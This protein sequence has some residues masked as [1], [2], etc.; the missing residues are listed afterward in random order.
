MFQRYT[1]LFYSH[2]LSRCNKQSKEDPMPDSAYLNVVG[3]SSNYVTDRVP[4]DYVTPRSSHHEEPITSYETVDLSLSNHTCTYTYVR[5]DLESDDELVNV[6]H[7]QTDYVDV[8]NP[9]VTRQSNTA[10]NANE[11][12]HLEGTRASENVYDQL[13]HKDIRMK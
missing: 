1:N 12:A 13:N 3:A 10:E 5:S 4:S 11:Y 9:E 7:T 2:P 8:G 6:T